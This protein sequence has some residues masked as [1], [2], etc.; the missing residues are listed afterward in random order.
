MLAEKDDWLPQNAAPFIR[1]SSQEA[2]NLTAPR[3]DPAAP[4]GDPNP[5]PNSLP[6]TV[7]KPIHPDD[8]SEKVKDVVY[9]Q[10]PPE[11]ETG[12]SRSASSTGS[13]F[14][15]DA[16]SD[17]SSTGEELSA[18][19]LRS[20]GTQDDGRSQSRADSSVRTASSGS[21]M[22]EP[23]SALSEDGAKPKRAGRR[24]RMMDLGKKMGE[25]LEEKRRNIE[26]KSRHIVEKMRENS[27]A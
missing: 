7:T 16:R 4:L 15:G 3:V 8:R 6:S 21:A 26:E 27:R 17:P 2:M 19:L 9:V 12:A 14:Y 20:S 22:E 23:S 10:K 13:S 11:S 18:P 25:K 1:I 5:K 24:A